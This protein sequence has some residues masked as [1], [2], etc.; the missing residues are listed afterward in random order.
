MWLCSASTTS[1][2]MRTSSTTATST[3]GSTCSLATTHLASSHAQVSQA[4]TL[5]CFL[6]IPI[7]PCSQKD[8]IELQQICSSSMA[9]ELAWPY[10]CMQQ[11]SSAREEQALKIFP[12]KAA[13]TVNLH[14]H[15]HSCFVQ[16]QHP[17][18]DLCREF[19]KS[20]TVLTQITA[21]T[22]CC[23]QMSCMNS[24]NC[25]ALKV[26]QASFRIIYMDRMNCYPA[27]AEHVGMRLFV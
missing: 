9:W 10:C 25:C 15:H 7:P 23:R 4:V 18:F 14:N 24:I 3:S 12:V 13:S 27:I 26:Q 1:T 19:V 20:S 6:T 8:A 2:C 11:W 17:I 16:S 22:V 5:G 21:P